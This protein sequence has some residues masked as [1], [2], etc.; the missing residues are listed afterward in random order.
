MLGLQETNVQSSQRPEVWRLTAGPLATVFAY[1]L[2]YSS[3]HQ[4]FCPVLKESSNR[5]PFMSWGGGGNAII[6]SE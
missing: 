6:R 1:F 4:F 5:D 3:W 2:P